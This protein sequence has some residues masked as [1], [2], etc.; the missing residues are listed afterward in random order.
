MGK[1]A[2]E[3]NYH[4]SF[5]IHMSQKTMG[6]QEQISEQLDYMHKDLKEN[7]KMLFD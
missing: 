3:I 6:R 7:I 5:S 1:V 4:I 2:D